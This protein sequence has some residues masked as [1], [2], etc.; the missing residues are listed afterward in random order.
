MSW[1]VYNL[2]ENLDV[3]WAK[4][5]REKQKRINYAENQKKIGQNILNIEK[6]EEE[7]DWN[8]VKQPR[9]A[10]EGTT[11]QEMMTM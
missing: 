11:P 3:L 4:E 2:R 8:K 9:L 10:G 5:Q 1:I 7:F 6:T